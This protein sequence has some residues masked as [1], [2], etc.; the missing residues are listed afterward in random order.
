[1]IPPIAFSSQEEG[2]PP[3]MRAAPCAARRIDSPMTG[4]NSYE[5][6]NSA[7]RIYDQPLIGDQRLLSREGNV[8]HSDAKKNGIAIMMIKAIIALLR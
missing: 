1:M 5:N 2:G 4:Q 3:L 6:Q 8:R 7:D